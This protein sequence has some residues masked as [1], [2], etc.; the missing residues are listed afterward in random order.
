MAVQGPFK[1][2]FDELF[3][4]G[5]G[6]VGAVGPVIDFDASTKDRKVQSRDKDSGLPVW[7]VDVMDFDPDARERTFKVK[8]A[9][10][11]QPVPPEA[12]DGLP[13]RPVV[14]DGVTVTPY[15]KEVGNG[16]SKIA[17]SLRASGMR[18]PGK[19]AKPAAGSS[20]ASTGTAGGS[21]SSSAA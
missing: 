8:F 20:G 2:A 7:S 1:I 3:P 11:V 12:L 17:Y 19:A 14:L 9:A 6:V 13:V 15:L 21:G 5:L 10:A 16:R 4:Y 18:A